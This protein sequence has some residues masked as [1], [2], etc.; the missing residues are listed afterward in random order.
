MFTWIGDDC[1]HIYTQA[2]NVSSIYL[3]SFQAYFRIL[4][5]VQI[6]DVKTK[7]LKTSH[8]IQPLIWIWRR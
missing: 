4:L 6:F 5:N 7:M 8:L 1:L 2:S 3:E